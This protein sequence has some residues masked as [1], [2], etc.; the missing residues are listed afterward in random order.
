MK[1]QKANGRNIFLAAL[2]LLLPLI[3]YGQWWNPLA[4]KDYNECIIKNMKEGMGKDAVEALQ[5][6]CIEKYPAPKESQS[7]INQRNKREERYK[8]CRID[9]DHYKVHI[10]LTIGE[11]EP[12]KTS[13]VLEGVKNFKYDGQSNT[14][15][16]Q[17]MNS[18]GISG[19]MLGF[20][21]SKQCYA[22][23]KDY[24]YSTYCQ[25]NYSGTESGVASQSFGSLRC[26]NLPREAKS[27][28][29]CKIGY[30]PFYDKFNDSLLDFLERYGYCK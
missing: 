28:G 20:T 7:S 5:S 23:I 30:S 12:A 21:N 3:S 1:Y 13:Q 25:K 24:T 17:N 14:V 26:G 15:S 10:H 11:R 4:P 29:F 22:E 16:F 18:F 6:A 2:S 19:I 9:E 27:M 8:K